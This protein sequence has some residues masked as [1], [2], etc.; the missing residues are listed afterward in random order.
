MLGTGLV[1]TRKVN[2]E[3]TIL[4]CAYTLPHSLEPK[5]LKINN[6]A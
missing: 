4:S 3:E 1:V 6:A 5:L 2:T